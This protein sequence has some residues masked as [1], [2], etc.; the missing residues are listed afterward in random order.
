MNMNTAIQSFLDNK[1][2]QFLALFSIFIVF[3]LT[4]LL[5]S[6]KVVMKALKK[7]VFRSRILIKIIP[8]DELKHIYTLKEQEE[9]RRKPNY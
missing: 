7:V 8:T 4:S 2:K 1:V 3:L 9:N 6:L 5:V